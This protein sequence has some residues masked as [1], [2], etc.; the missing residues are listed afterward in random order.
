[1]RRCFKALAVLSLT[2]ALGGCAATQARM[3]T[4]QMVDD[5]ARIRE[6]QVLRNVSAAI[7]DHDMVPAA[8]LLGAGQAS[9]STDASSNLHLP[10][11]SFT[12][13]SRALDVSA[14]DSWTAQWQVSAV[15]NAEDLRRLRNL[16]VL[17]ASTD[18]QY[19]QLQAYFA[20]HPD[21]RPAAACSGEPA[22]AQGARPREEAASQLLASDTLSEECPP[23]YGA[24]QIPKWR[25]ALD[26]I[27]N[28]DSIGCKLYQERRPEADRG[29]LPFRRWLYW[30]A[31]GGAWGPE[32]PASEPQSLGRAGKWELGVTSR[33]CFNDFVIL[34]QS[35]TPAT[36][37]ASGQGPKLML[38]RP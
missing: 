18:E 29:G 38:T 14:S 17:I 8:I 11:F 19:D 34:V 12:Q 24:G 3:N 26:I 32:T 30:R 13:P 9:V 2:A 28:G 22:P 33:A 27:E 25:R 20:R 1:M 6:A 23:G 31:A 16:Y 15:T 21:R 7:S 37:N 36:V 35:A 5:V 4:L 10:D